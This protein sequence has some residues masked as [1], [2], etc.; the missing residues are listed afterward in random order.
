M[1]CRA[2]NQLKKGPFFPDNVDTGWGGVGVWV[3][4]LGLGFEV[5][6]NFFTE[7]SLVITLEPH[8]GHTKIPRFLYFILENNSSAR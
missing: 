5:C 3:L 4:G 8:V 7:L 2:V 1:T 6:W